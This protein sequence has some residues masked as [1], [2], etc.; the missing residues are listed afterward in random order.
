[1][2]DIA[3][4]YSLFL[5]YI[6]RFY[7]PNIWF[8]TMVYTIIAMTI[9]FLLGVFIS[10]I[11]MLI[12]TAFP[13][14]F[15]YIFLIKNRDYHRALKL[16]FLWALTIAIYGIILAIIFPDLTAKAILN[17]TSYKEEMFIWIKTGVGAESNP[18]LFIPI[19]LK[20][21]IIFLLTSLG[22]MSMIGIIFGSY[23]MNYMDYYVGMLYLNV[24]PNITNYLIISIL[25]WPIWAICRVIG[26]LF[27]GLAASIPLTT[28]LFRQVLP[29]KEFIRYLIIGIILLIL[30]IILK[31]ILAPIYQNILH[32]VVS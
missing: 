11:F 25:G 32:S 4:R 16:S 18:A 23:L 28:Y 6:S 7:K 19:H 8:L 22:S 29:K 17:S 30:D 31:T 21:F 10:P 20:H 3:Q 13:F 27:I 9:G 1:M 5:D 2:I 12:L 24:S 14:Y 15:I 26:Y